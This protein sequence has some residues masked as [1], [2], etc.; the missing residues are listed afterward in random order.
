MKDE[1]R[2]KQPFDVFLAHNSKDKAAVRRLANALRKRQL[3]PWLDIEQLEPGGDWQ[4]GLEDGIKTSRTAAILVGKDGL[5]PWQA[6]EIKAVLQLAARRRKKLIPVLLPGAS[7]KPHL[8]LFITNRT[9]LDLRKGLTKQGID[10]LIWGITGKKPTWER[11]PESERPA[12]LGLK[13]LSQE[14][15]EETALPKTYRSPPVARAMIPIEKAD[16]LRLP[17]GYNPHRLLLKELL[18]R[19]DTVKRNRL[20]VLDEK[21]AAVYIIHRAWLTRFLAERS[22]G[23][24]ALPDIERLT[25]ADLK[26]ARRDLF[27]GI[28][29]WGCVPRDATLSDATSLMERLPNCSDVFVTESGRVDEPVIGWVTDN[30]IALQSQA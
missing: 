27:Y 11:Q 18:D 30:Q 23:G 28:L 15:P 6:E 22:L 17:Q 12:S 29:T 25:I 5:G 2:K 26:T 13:G 4:K 1:A 20:P 24:M 3:K 8:P 9:W 21:G 7:K 10:K 14:R 19:M 16:I